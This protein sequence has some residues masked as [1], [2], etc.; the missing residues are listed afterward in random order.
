MRVGH[1]RK[2][3]FSYLYLLYMNKNKAGF[4]LGIIL[5]L[6]HL[7]WSV[8]VA[9]GIAQPLLDFIFRIHFL[10]N[11]FMI[12]PFGMKRAVALIVITSVIGYGIGWVFAWLWDRFH[13]VSA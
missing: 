7:V 10:N 9:I 8:L 5:G 4:V 13:T 2:V 11:P 1:K 12:A 6:L 3:D